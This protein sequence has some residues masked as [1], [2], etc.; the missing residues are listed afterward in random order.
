MKLKSQWESTKLPKILMN[1]VDAR[2]A[3]KLELKLGH[4]EN[5][6]ANI[7]LERKIQQ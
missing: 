5:Q 6:I 4:H 3:E 2:E 7:Q 1:N